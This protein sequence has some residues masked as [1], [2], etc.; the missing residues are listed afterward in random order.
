MRFKLLV[1]VRT[2]IQ[3]VVVQQR[4]VVLLHCAWQMCPD[5][6]REYGNRTWQALVQIRQKRDDIRLSKNNNSGMAALERALARAKKE[7]RKHVLQIDNSKHGLDF[8]FLTLAHA[9]AFTQYLQRVGPPMRVQTTQRK[10]VS[11]DVK[12][13]TANVKHT[14]TCDLVP[15]CKHDLLLIHKSAARTKL[16]G[17]VVVVTKVADGGCVHVTDASPK[18]QNLAESEM[19]LTA[20]AYYRNEKYY[21]VV[22]AA[23]RMTR[24]VVLDVELCEPQDEHVKYAVLYQGPKSGVAKYALADIEVA[25]E[26]DFGVN[27]ETYHCV[28]PLGH[29]V[30]PGD[31]VLGYDLVS[32]AV[33]AGVG[34]DAKECLQNNY[35]WPDVVLVKKVSDG[36]ELSSNDATIEDSKP[37]ISKRRERRRKRK[38]GKR[39]RELEESA[40]RMGFF[41]DDDELED[42]QLEEGVANDPHLEAELSA[43]EQN[44]AALDMPS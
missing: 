24:F 16:A 25:R 5:C 23:H 4:V 21:T 22:Q 37:G 2:E 31:V 39:M 19:E 3:N 26:S 11:S 33:T 15:I 42:G 6:K 44:L 13:N 14:I 30:S 29:L 43:L 32:S 20:E 38:E 9:Q 8:Y 17:R 12:N 40:I 35:A 7:L 18:R 28:S 10:L 27:D 41:E 36:G 34:I 1:T